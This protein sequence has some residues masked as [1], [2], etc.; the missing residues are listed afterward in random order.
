MVARLSKERGYVE[1]F[2]G[3]KADE[4]HWSGIPMPSRGVLYI[5][6]GGT[7]GFIASGKRVEL[8]ELDTRVQR[9]CLRRR[10]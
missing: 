10:G 2:E 1:H 5:E 8:P 7:S 9:L 4:D 6:Q 3:F